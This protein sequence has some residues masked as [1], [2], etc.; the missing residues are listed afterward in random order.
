[1]RD[2]QIVKLSAHMRPTGRFLNASCFIDLIEPRITIRLQRARE[3][4][5]VRE[6]ELI[7]FSWR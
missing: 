2:L 7:G 1:V 4:A 3:L 6:A 5:Q